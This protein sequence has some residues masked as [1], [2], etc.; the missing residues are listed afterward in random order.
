MPAGSAFARIL[1]EATSPEQLA[2][3]RGP[4]QLDE[5]QAQVLG[6]VLERAEVWMYAGGLSD[7]AIRSGLMVPVADPAAA[8]SEALE[9]QG[10]GSRL[11]VLPQGPLTVATSLR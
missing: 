6:R 5:W 10:A 1:G 3:P 4:G 11:C 2:R 7:D 8:V 9:R